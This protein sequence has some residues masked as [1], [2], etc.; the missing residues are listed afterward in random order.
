MTA[1][2]VQKEMNNVLSAKKVNYSRA[3]RLFKTMN[4]LRIEEG[5]KILTLPNLQ[6]RFN[7]IDGL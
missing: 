1:I 4:I 3:Y 7:D 6:K 2:E 5:L